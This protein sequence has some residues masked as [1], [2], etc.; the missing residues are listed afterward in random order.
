MSVERGVD[1]ST[2]ALVAFGGAGPLHACD[3]ADAAGIPTVIVPGAAG[4]LSAVGLL[5]S[6][7]RRELVRSW[8]TPRTSP[9]ASMRRST[10]WLTQ[11]V[12]LLDAE[13]TRRGRHD[14]DR[15]GLPLRA[16][17]A[18]SCGSVEIDDFAAGAPRPQRL[19]PA[20]VAGRGDRA[21]SGRR[22]ASPC[23]DRTTCS[24]AGTGQVA[25]VAVA[26]PQVV[27]P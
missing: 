2:L 3:L 8:P 5:T 26:D 15:T 17:R 25:V 21:P 12:E 18:T 6:P 11:A 27:S 16:G 10:S 19:R 20:A 23:G 14:R 13:A 4:V 24:H 7:R 22:G 1:P 9:M